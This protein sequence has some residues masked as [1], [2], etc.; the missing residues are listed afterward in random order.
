MTSVSP[1]LALKEYGV[2]MPEPIK[3]TRVSDGRRALRLVAASSVTVRPV[4]WAWD[5]RLACGSVSLLGGREGI[6]KTTLGN[7]LA[8]DITRGRLPGVYFGQPKGVIIAASEDSWEHTIVPRLMAADADLD[9]VFRVDVT[10]S[11]SI[12][13][14]L[15]LP[16]DVA[17]L[18]A[19]IVEADVAL[20]LLDPLMSRLDASLDTHRDA[21]VRLALEPIAAVANRTGVVVLGLIHVNKGGS[22]DPLTALMGSRAFAA[23]ARAVLFVMVDPDDDSVR[24]LGQPKNNLGRADLT[25]LTFRI[26]SAHVADTPEGPVYTGK[27][28]WTGTTDVTI[29]EA[30]TTAGD[31]DDTRTAATEA[32]D[33]LLDYLKSQG[34]AAEFVDVRRE[35]GRAGHNLTSVQRARKRAAVTTIARGF[36]RRTRWELPSHVTP[37]APSSHVTPGESEMNEMNDITEDLGSQSFQ[38]CQSFQSSH[39]PPRGDTT[40][41]AVGDPAVPPAPTAS[42]DDVDVWADAL[43]VFGDDIAEPEAVA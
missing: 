19:A 22:A 25:T 42:A 41:A 7:Q 1:L 13:T 24:L 11:D 32:T 4:H 29:R 31:A 37:G 16:R 14:E 34:G 20:V 17:A 40:G 35:A 15:S 43:R 3:D 27:L 9:R 26:E 18:E 21:E 5:G 10:S 36:P 2:A 8:A 33:W 12:A 23:V 39:T 38:S 28:V 6:G 30:M